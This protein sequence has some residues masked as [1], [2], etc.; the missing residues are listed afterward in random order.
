M[1]IC[2]LHERRF[3]LLS[4][5]QVYLISL[6]LV[7]LIKLFPVLSSSVCS[8]AVKI[9]NHSPVQKSSKQFLIRTNPPAIVQLGVPPIR[10]LVLRVLNKTAWKDL[11]DSYL[12]SRI[13][14]EVKVLGARKAL[15]LTMCWKKTLKAKGLSSTR[16]SHLA[17]W[18]GKV[19]ILGHSDKGEEDQVSL[20]NSQSHLLEGKF[21]L[22]LKYLNVR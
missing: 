21:S 6:L 8:V 3:R 10:V 12:Y 19:D 9:E 17:C 5:R 11:P 13:R 2:R 18:I 14:L 20:R 4:Q 1:V 15:Q 16:F 22:L 7:Y